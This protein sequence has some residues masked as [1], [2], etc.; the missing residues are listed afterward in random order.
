MQHLLPVINA[1]IV[2]SLLCAVGMVLRRIGTFTDASIKSVSTLIMTVAQP[3]LMISSTQFEYSPDTLIGF[4]QATVFIFV[5]LV[6]LIL[7]C[8]ALGRRLKPDT[9]KVMPMAVSMSNIGFIGVPII[10][11]VYGEGE[12]MLYLTAFIIGFNLAAWTVGISL[13]TGLHR[14]IFRN[15]INPVLIAAV[16]GLTLFLF[17]IPLPG[18]AKECVGY[19]SDLNTPLCMLLLGARLADLKKQ[20]LLDAGVW[21]SAGLKTLAIPL[22]VF[23]LCRLFG[24]GSLV[25]GVLVI[26]SAMPSAAMGQI[27]AENYGGDVYFAVKAVSISTVLSLFTIPLIQWVTGI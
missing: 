14:G 20:D 27:M 21:I 19:L 18:P 23:A 11:A 10:R 13:F 8:W 12:A 3:A 25:T 16:F 17:R 5:S 2:I 4:C 15:L 26:G 6:V 9:R 24:F 7:A 1:L 22:L